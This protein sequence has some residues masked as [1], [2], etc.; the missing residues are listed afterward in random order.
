MT[1]TRTST[2]CCSLSLGC[3]Y[4]IRLSLTRNT[5]ECEWVTKEEKLAQVFQFKRVIFL[6]SCKL[7]LLLFVILM[8]SFAVLVVVA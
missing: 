1:V 6:C 5:C 2:S 3:V 7:G 4:T 8:L